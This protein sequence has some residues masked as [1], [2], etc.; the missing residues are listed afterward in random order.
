MSLSPLAPMLNRP[1][2]VKGLGALG[3]GFF[4]SNSS[5]AGG[6]VSRIACAMTPR[7]PSGAKLAIRLFGSSPNAV[8]ITTCCKNTEGAARRPQG[9]TTLSSKSSGA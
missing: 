8:Q 4:D 7:A 3:L 2:R 9:N 5:K 1:P 6:A